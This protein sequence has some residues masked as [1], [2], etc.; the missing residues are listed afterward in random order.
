MA[1]ALD[2]HDDRDDSQDRGSNGADGSTLPV[3]AVFDVLASSRRRAVI[4]HFLERSSADEVPIDDLVDAVARADESN[5]D[6]VEIDLRHHH[7]PALADYGI[8]ALE[9]TNDRV[10]YRE[11][12]AVERC[13]EVA[14]DSRLEST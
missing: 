13:L 8:V 5:R 9:W 1:P 2:G 6:A 14:A 7:L 10:R 4:G 11:S 3:D 12:P